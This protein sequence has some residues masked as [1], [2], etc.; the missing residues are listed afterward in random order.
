MTLDTWLPFFVV[1][2][3]ATLI[4]GPAMLLIATHSLSYGWRRSMATIFGNVSGLVIL[5][6]LS[7][8]GLSALI[9][10]SHT[11]FLIVKLCGAAYLFYLGLKIWR[12]G[13][14]PIDAQATAVPAKTSNL[15]LQGIVLA[16]SNPK[17]IIF[18]TALFPQ[19][20]KLEQ[21]VPRQF[22]IFVLTL[23]CLSFT[24]LLGCAFVSR[25]SFATVRSLSIGNALSKLFGSV[26]MGAA[27][28]LL[29][30]AK[31]TRT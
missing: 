17:A 23:C 30:T 20:I 4:P 15:Y 1:A 25:K 11:V 28:W 7:V 29:T 6:L 24:C 19:F 10:S 14:K 26:F 12:S 2:L 8:L 21:S 31:A 3:I 9:V 18:T 22:F 5:S 16:L 13:I 27:I